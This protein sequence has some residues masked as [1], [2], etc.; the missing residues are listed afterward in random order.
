[1]S[2][3]AAFF[4]P[5]IMRLSLLLSLIVLLP[6][7]SLGKKEPLWVKQNPTDSAFYSAVVHISRKAP[8][9][10][11][12]A[13]D[14]ALK[15]ISAQI[16]VT[17][18]ANLALK[19]S[20]TNGVPSA[21]IVNQIVSSTRNKL[22][23]V[24]LAGTYQNK[25]DYWAYYRLSK[26]EYQIWRL[27]QRDL[28]MQQAI[29][30]LEEYDAATGDLA[31]GITSLLKALELVVDFAD[32]DLGTVYRGKQVNLYNELLYRLHH[33]PENIQLSFSQPELAIVAKQREKK[34]FPVS[35]V[36]VA[37]S[38][39]YPA[40]AFPLV[41]SFAAG[42]G[43][44]VQQALTDNAGSAELYIRRITDF[45]DPQF[46]ELRPDKQYWLARLEN[47]VVKKLLNLV[48]FPP[49]VLKLKVRHPRAFLD[50]SFDNVAGYGYKE[51][52]IKK[53]QDLDLEMV[54]DS[55]QSDYTFKM[56]LTSREGEYISRLGVF[57]ASADAYVELLNSLDGSSMANNSLTGV[58]STGTDLKTAIRMSE[59]NAAAE[60][61]DKLLYNLV[62]QFIMF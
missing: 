43:D 19:E 13:R 20:E 62:E 60:I 16:S 49:A 37:S 25:T 31:P 56:I 46:I 32:L 3:I 58:K 11:D 54:A 47:P 39:F 36:H 4:S 12:F 45:S 10:V 53:L 40:K 6:G 15:D 9:Y 5:R 57:S 55:T 28:A 29:R 21:E 51:L 44:I 24:Q 14:N 22:A 52:I 59:L 8:N 48:Q 26:S 50:Y 2:V 30:F 42:A 23:N 18:D 1:M 34:I 27:K 33:L 38:S 35:A 61:C 41:F 17:I 7:C